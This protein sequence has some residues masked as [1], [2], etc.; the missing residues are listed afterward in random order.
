MSENDSR[1]AASADGR[2]N[3]E[4][5]ADGMGRIRSAHAVIDDYIDESLP[6]FGITTMCGADFQT[7]LPPAAVRRF[8]RINTIQESTRVGDGTMP[9]VDRGRRP[10]RRAAR[11]DPAVAAGAA[12]RI[13]HTTSRHCSSTT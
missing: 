2:A 6:A 8:G 5:S 12:P 9:L 11:G 13:S 4:M 3:V 10:P 1:E 7:T